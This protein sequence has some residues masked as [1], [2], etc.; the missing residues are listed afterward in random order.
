MGTVRQ[1]KDI[2]GKVYLR[3]LLLNLPGAAVLVGILFLVRTRIELPGWFMALMVAIWLVKDGILFPFVWRAYD[4]DRPGISRTMTG[5]TGVVKKP[6]EPEGL[7]QIGGE[8]WKAQNIGSE[9]ILERDT[10][11]R[12]VKRRGLILSVERFDPANKL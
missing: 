4:W 2:P 9:N 8:L 3:Y 6:L 11:V 5:S 1:L 7:V 10:M 12:V